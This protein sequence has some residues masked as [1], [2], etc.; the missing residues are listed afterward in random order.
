MFANQ[1][2]TAH[3]A[4]RI[5]R[6]QPGCAARIKQQRRRRSRALELQEE[7]RHGVVFELVRLRTLKN[8]RPRE[9]EAGA[10]SAGDGGATPT[11]EWRESSFSTD[12]RCISED[13]NTAGAEYDNG[14]QQ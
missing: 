10:R 6:Y 1:M 14:N 9:Q 4:H 8:G 5:R 2:R 13:G 3:A 11:G 12:R 7:G